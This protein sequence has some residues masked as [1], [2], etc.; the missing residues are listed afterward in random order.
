M[1]AL[2]EPCFFHVNTRVGYDR[3]MEFAERLNVV[4]SSGLRPT[5][6][7]VYSVIQGEFPIWVKFNRI[8]PGF[9]AA[10]AQWEMVYT[11][12]S[13]RRN[14]WANENSALKEMVLVRKLVLDR[15]NTESAVNGNIF[16][17]ID[18]DD[19]FRLVAEYLESVE[20]SVDWMG[21][22]RA[23]EWSPH[24]DADRE[25]PYRMGVSEG[26]IGW[27]HDGNYY[28][29]RGHTLCSVQEVWVPEYVQ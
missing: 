27:D 22:Q 11:S 5:Q 23:S 25:L 28:A 13:S 4:W 8:S 26:R 6:R 3:L 12:N 1:Q 29:Q 19:T 17:V 7:P 18:S 21:G 9:V 14:S 10:A 24:G 2:L 15:P 16:F 20:P